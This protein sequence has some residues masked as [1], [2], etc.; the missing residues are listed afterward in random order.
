MGWRTGE[1]TGGWALVTGEHGIG[2]SSLLRL[3]LEAAARCQ[4][5]SAGADE[6]EQLIP[7][8]LME[9][10]LGAAAPKRDL[11]SAGA[12]TAA[13][14]VFAGDVVAAG[15]EQL[16]AK[17]DQLCAVSPLVLVTED[18]HWAD[19]ASVLV[20]SRLARATAQLPLLLVGSYRPGTGRDDLDRLH[21][22]VLARGGLVVE[23]SPLP[24]AEV[25]ELVGGLVGGRLAPHLAEL[26]THAGG[27]PLYA[28]ELADSLVSDGQV[29]VAGG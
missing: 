12:L 27:N 20:W 26:M 19:E 24:D 21:R 6:L 14:G 17:V 13:A 9:K 3:G 2:K 7:L 15:L 18:L 28:H 11:A 1:G 23:L 25:A 22:G 8:R 29:E 4:V 16:L 5:L 10:C